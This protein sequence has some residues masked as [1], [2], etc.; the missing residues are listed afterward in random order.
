[1]KKLIFS[2]AVAAAVV[3]YAQDED[4][5]EEETAEETVAEEEAAEESDGKT[6][7][8]KS[9]QDNGKTFFL[10]P[11]T[12]TLD[13]EAQVLIP[14][15]SE[16]Q[17]V[18]EGKFYPLGS[19]YRTVGADSKL[20]IQL[21]TGVEVAMK[22]NSSFATLAQK[23][24]VTTRTI[25]L[26]G[27]TINVTLP[28]NLP[29]GQF[30]ITS[31][32]FTV[33][34][35][36]GESSY[37]YEQTGDGDKCWVKCLTGNLAVNGRHFSILPLRASQGFVI[38]NSSD[39]LLTAI[40]GK[41]GDLNVKLDTGLWET[42]DLDTKEKTSEQRFAD[43]RLSPKMAVRIHRMMPE[44]GTD[45]SVTTMTFDANGN[46]RDLY[47]FAENHHETTGSD[48]IAEDNK[49]AEEAAKKA[50]EASDTEAVDVDVSEDAGDD[51]GEEES[52]GGSDDSGSE[53]A[54]DD[55]L[56]F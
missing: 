4:F 18:E 27:G 53:D 1:M 47:W 8:S 14:T 33:I 16:W 21:G 31:P 9:V 36:A 45:M 46:R 41:A 37:V 44:I 3:A 43:F 42:I 19:T 35:A 39:F 2:M 15:K 54:G 20:K 22:G 29:D 34:N 38:R 17:P 48:I 40:Y 49:E 23:L 10:L 26:K 12:R 50:A 52:A 25:A 13:G 55:E 28:R 24:E 56:D 30:F 51:E 7:D 32:G 6:A 11:L 5:D